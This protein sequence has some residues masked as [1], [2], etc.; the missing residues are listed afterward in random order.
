LNGKAMFFGGTAVAA[1]AV[2]GGVVVHATHDV[3]HVSVA[4]P[5]D[6][7]TQLSAVQIT[8]P[9]DQFQLARAMACASGAGGVALRCV[10]TFS[11]NARFGKTAYVIV[12]G[13]NNQGSFAAVQAQVD[14]N[15]ASLQGAGMISATETDTI[16]DKSGS[17][18]FNSS[19]NCEQATKDEVQS[20]AVC[21]AQDSDNTVVATAIFPD[22]WSNV[23]EVSQPPDI[24][25]AEALES[26]ALIGVYA[27]L[28]PPG[29]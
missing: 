14:K 27:A 26:R 25:R 19:V 20:Y 3:P 2:I 16:S 5:V 4:A 9:D 24:L 7:A 11:D 21:L 13:L 28:A 12:Y 10:Q 18:V 29:N 6:L 15:L 17:N 22:K 23:T 1:L 8:P